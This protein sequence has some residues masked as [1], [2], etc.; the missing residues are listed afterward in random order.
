MLAFRTIITSIL[1]ISSLHL[2]AQGFSA[3][4]LKSA[5]TSANV[6]D[7]YY[8]SVG[9]NLRLYN[10]IEYNRYGHGFT[11]TPFF[12][13]SDFTVGSVYY[14]GVLYPGV[15][16]LYDVV[17]DELIVKDY[18]KNY[19][20]KLVKEKVDYFDLFEH[21]FIHLTNKNADENVPAEGYYEVLLQGK[22]TVLKKAEKK[23]EA[24]SKAE[25]ATKFTSYTR[26]YVKKD[27][28]YY[29]IDNPNA[30]VR[31]FRDKKTEVRKYIRTNDLG[32]KNMEKLITETTSYYNSITK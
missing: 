1:A 17:Q 7:T 8:K 10:G 32:K 11:G 5:S 26:L 27:N 15:A 9:T 14:D 3:D 30:L 19:E 24:S 28:N 23:I 29:K 12:N 22:V 4:T 16:L 18:T 21:R 31:A 20:M 13:N 25:E 6:I 2:F